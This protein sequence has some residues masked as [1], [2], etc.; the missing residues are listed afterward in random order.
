LFITITSS[1]DALLTPP[2]RPSWLPAYIPELQGL[3]GI[4]VLAV[5]L[6]HSHPRFEGTWFY[7]A[8]LWG[9]AGVNLFFVLSGFLITSILLESR[10]KP[11]YFRNFYGRRALR[12]WPVYLLVLIVCYLNAPWFVGLQ[13]WQAIRTAPW[14]AYLLFVQ[15]LFHLALPPVI[16]PTW[17]LA[18]E[19][20]YYFVWAP[21]VRALERPWALAI[22]LAGAMFVSPLFRMSHFEWITPTHTLTHLDGIAMGSLLAL[23]LYNLAVRRRV[24]LALGLGGVVLGFAA[25][26]TVAGGTAWLDT[27]LT[28]G[29]GGTVL[30]MIASTGARSPLNALLRRGPL[31]YLGRISY[32]MYMV[33]IMVFVYFGWFDLRM[34][35]YGVA[36]N[37]AVVAFRLGA[38]IAAASLLWYGFESRILRLKRFFSR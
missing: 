38:S 32:G 20:Q 27:A 1:E 10:G 36:G 17:S 25:A 3:R 29:F 23:G 19:E 8:S 2:Q 18:I 5:V 15:N 30:A 6:Y 37:L 33:H 22:V 4:A 21:V 13:V 14:W 7:R 24:W 35:A 11:R 9:W 31:A 12:I 16:G 34:D 26:A 28:A